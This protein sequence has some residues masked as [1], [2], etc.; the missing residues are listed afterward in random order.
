[1]KCL[2]ASNIVPT[3]KAGS[4]IA[5]LLLVFLLSASFAPVAPDTHTPAEGPYRMKTVVIDAG[6]GGHDHGCSGKKSREKDVALKIALDLGK[7]IKAAYPDINVVYTR[8]TDVFIELHERA[9]I[10]NRNKADLFICIHCN[11]NTST[12]PFGTETYVMGLHKTEA[13]LSVAKREND[14]IL[15]EDNYTDHY[16]GFNP[17]D[18]TAHIIFSLFQHAYMQQSINFASKVE[19]A[20]ANQG[21]RSSRGV[22]QAGFLVLWKTSMPAVLIET[23]FLTNAQE[24]DFLASTK[25]QSTI[26][27]CI[28]SAFN[29]YKTELEGS[30]VNADNI[31]VQEPVFSEGKASLAKEESYAQE[32]EFRVQFLASKELYTAGKG[33]LKAAG[34]QPVF[35]IYENGWHKYRSAPFDNFDAAAEAQRSFK[36]AGYTDAFLIAHR[37]G[38]TMDINEARSLSVR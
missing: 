19:A 27:G 20:F 29:Q 12:K 34:G 35:Y 13:N 3:M 10:A 15:M 36:A 26:A 18:P 7:Q 6:H 14:V 8:T 37:A 31:I 28:F 2:K 25:G 11:A 32:V 16:D 17:N 38:K 9:A 33:P 23:G 30:K 21:G 5:S 4:K 1:M 24:E 22:K